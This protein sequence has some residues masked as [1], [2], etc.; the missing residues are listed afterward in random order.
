MSSRKQA[1]Q[2]FVRAPLLS[3]TFISNPLPLIP[4]S[5]T[6]Y[7]V[8][9]IGANSVYRS[10]VIVND[11]YNDIH[12]RICIPGPGVLKLARA[13]QCLNGCQTRRWRFIL[14]RLLSHYSECLLHFNVQ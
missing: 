8:L 12:I 6:E 11:F 4:G 1:V 9:K 5:A 7:E 14:I 2:K 13:L 3:S 10:K